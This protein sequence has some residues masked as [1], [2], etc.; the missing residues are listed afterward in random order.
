MNTI[1]KKILD[2][3]RK[4][5]IFEIQLQFT[6]LFGTL[7]NV[8]ISQAKL[9]EAL[10][11]GVWFDGSSIEGFSRICESD[12]YL[13]P[14]PSTYRKL[15]WQKQA[16]RFICDIFRPDGTPYES[17]PRFILKKALQEAKKQGFIYNV[18]PEIEFF[19]FR[20]EEEDS[21]PLTHDQAGYF[22]L[23]PQDTGVQVRKEIVRNLEKLGLE[24][25]THH[26]EVAPGQHEIDFKYADAL[27]TADRTITFKHV[28]KLI[29]AKNGL[30]ATFMPKPRAGINGSGMHT[31][32]SLFNLK[33][34]NVF[35]NK[36]NKY[37]LSKIAQHF[38]AG[39]MKYI[40]GISAVISPTVNS[41]KRLI[42]GFEAPCYI[43]WGQ[44]NRSA[45]VRIP[46]TFKDRPQGTRVELR[47]PDPSCNPYLAFAVMLS[48]GMSGIREKLSL[49]KPIEEDVYQF[50]NG[51]LSRLYID[52]LPE[53][54][55]HAIHEME[56]YDLV[57]KTLGRESYE[58]Y[59]RAKKKEW[60]TY[61]TSVSEW[62]EENYFK[63][64]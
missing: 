1:N 24:I 29:A 44:I 51:K 37:N 13:K 25:E 28:V 64:A 60:D 48:A 5:K 33:G 18:G 23:A 41:Y 27:T 36:K 12:M 2:Q 19:L 9:K 56:K 34:K 20:Q 54:L 21:Y 3:V 16:A 35:F 62:E 59:L 39:Q 49:S 7:K 40:K 22:D 42:P 30:V 63:Q 38:I 57:K 11:R 14:D 4:D 26:H 55:G 50:N 46:K 61:R 32:Q 45:L 31:H 17:D 8:I 6:D 15:P 47:S 52:V 53:S 10:E 58:K 43:C